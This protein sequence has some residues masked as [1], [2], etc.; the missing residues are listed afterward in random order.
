MSFNQNKKFFLSTILLSIIVG[1]ILIALLYFF[2]WSLIVESY[3][4][5]E[6][7]FGVVL[8]IVCRIGIVSGMTIYTF[9]QWFK[10]EEQYFSDIPFLFG[11]FFLFLIFGKSLDLFNNLIY[12][13]FDDNLV[14]LVLKA[15]YIISVLDLFPMIYLSMDMLLF[16]LSLKDRFVKLTKEKYREKIKKQILILILIIEFIAGIIAPNLTLLSIL[17]PIIIIP[18]LLTIAWLFNFAWRNKRLSQV[19]TYILMIGFALYLISSIVRPVTQFIVGESSL[20][21]I[22]AESMD[23]VVFAIIFI[24]FYKKSNY[25]SNQ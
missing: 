2:N 1:I 7:A 16:S 6:G 18:S 25:P 19:S 11:M 20:F 24:G 13:K 14:L 10:Q 12:F 23:L 3:F 4:E 8:A 17:Y 9:H 21:V 5:N 15:R 22:I